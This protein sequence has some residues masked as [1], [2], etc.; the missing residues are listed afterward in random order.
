MKKIL[1]FVV[2][3]CITFSLFAKETEVDSTKLLMDQIE[4]NIKYTKSGTVDLGNCT[5]TIPKGFKYLD[6]A[7]SRYVLEDLWQNP[8]S[9]QKT[10]GMLFPE[11]AGA[12]TDNSWAFEISMDEM[13]YVKDKDAQK[14]D[15][16]DIMK[17]MKKDNIDENKTRVEMGYGKAVLIGWASKP[18]YDKDKNVLH[19]AK[20]IKFGDDSINTLNYNIRYLCRKG[21]LVVNAIASVNQLDLVKQNIPNIMQS[22]EFKSGEKYSDF[23]PSMDKV[24]AYGIGGLVAGKVLAKAGVFVFLLKYIKIIGIAVVAFFGKIWS[25][26]TGKKKEDSN[27]LPND[28]VQPNA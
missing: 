15:Y 6:S 11:E 9:A 2:S 8:P 5:L 23:N 22:V 20:E 26:I 21:V 19:W 7:Q 3:L 4:S 12:F 25:M 10:L 18:F 17:D 16:D 24:A 28:D 14:M 13:G 27:P 1:F